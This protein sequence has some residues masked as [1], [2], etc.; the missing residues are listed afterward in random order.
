MACLV[1]RFQEFHG[2]LGFASQVLPWI[3]PFLAPGYA[4]LAAAK[5]TTTVKVPEMVAMVCIFIRA[6]FS[7]G[8]R[9]IPCVVPGLSRDGCEV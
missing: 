9:K 8:L 5:K 2:C 4:W 3:K 6:K 7:Q 1:R